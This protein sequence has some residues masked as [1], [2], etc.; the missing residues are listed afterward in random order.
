MTEAKVRYEIE[1]ITVKPEALKKLGTNGDIDPDL[2]TET[3]VEYR[4]AKP[5]AMKRAKA[6]Y[7]RDVIKFKRSCRNTVTVQE[8]RYT[9]PYEQY[10]HI[11][12]W[13]PVGDTEE[14]S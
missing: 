2:D 14:I 11:W 7:Q 4:D 9:Q 5:Q 1:S 13:E 12:E 3:L 10:P 6:I 8:Q